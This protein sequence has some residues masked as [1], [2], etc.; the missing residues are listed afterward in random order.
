[1]GSSV[2]AEHAGTSRRHQQA[3]PSAYSYEYSASLCAA[4]GST[5]TGPHTGSTRGAR[6]R[7]ISSFYI[8]GAPYLH[9][10]PTVS[11]GLCK[12]VP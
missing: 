5:Y 9:G 10:P 4:E 6:T 3:Q 7:W 11:C 2:A 12:R 1:M 8:H